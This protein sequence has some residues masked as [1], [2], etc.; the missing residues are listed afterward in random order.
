MTSKSESFSRLTLE[1]S[2]KSIILPFGRRFGGVPLGKYHTSEL[3]SD[4]MS[5]CL[6]EK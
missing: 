3:I 1:M 4:E 2:V 6:Y 5:F